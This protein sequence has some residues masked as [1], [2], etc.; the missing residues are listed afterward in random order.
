MAVWAAL[1]P[2][3]R[4]RMDL[5]P[6]ELGLLLLCLGVGA[7]VAMPISGILAS[8]FGCRLVILT[9]G[10]I[11]CLV[12]P[13]LSIVSSTLAE[14][15]TLCV[16]GAAIGTLDVATSVQAVI[17]ENAQGKPL[18]SGFHA[19][20]SVGGFFGAGGMS[21]LMWLGTSPLTAC[22]V[23]AAAIGVILFGA[24]PYLLSAAVEQDTNAT[25]F[26][27]PHGAVIIIGLLCFIAFLAEGAILDWGA[28]LLTTTD[29]YTPSQGGIGYAIFAGAMTIGRLTGDWFVRQLGRRRVLLVGGLCTA[30]GFFITVLASSP[31][32]ALAGFLLVGAG[33]SNIVP[34][35]FTAAGRQKDKDMPAGVAISIITTIGYMGVLAGPALIGFIA[36][37]SSL[38]LAFA[39]LGAA[40][41]VVAASSG[42]QFINRSNL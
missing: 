32:V 13:V 16:F 42:F 27:I 21:L 24:A 38:H 3:V 39:G 26:A 37:A 7:L 15:A 33:A 5:G 2:F 34:I 4:I 11:A 19:L 12:L 40:M 25:V 8:R 36:G 14:A 41:L 35:L 10:A 23:M 29:G 28:I 22:C 9:S 18:M 6:A 30:V 17:V 1:V 31:F 20:Y